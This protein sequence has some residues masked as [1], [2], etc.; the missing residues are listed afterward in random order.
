MRSRRWRRLRLGRVTPLPAPPR[1]PL[2][3][4]HCAPRALADSPG[5][6]ARRRSTL[7]E[8]SAPNT[9]SGRAYHDGAPDLEA[10]V[11]RAAT[12]RTPSGRPSLEVTR[13]LG[14]ARVQP[15][16]R[17]ALLHGGLAANRARPSSRS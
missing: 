11:A 8:S 6:E 17:A 3:R 14:A 15:C 2:V 16:T 1:L 5:A 10:L 13:R 12:S 7:R 4:S 9:V